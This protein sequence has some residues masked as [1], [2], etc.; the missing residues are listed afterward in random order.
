MV[1][2]NTQERTRMRNEMTGSR[3]ER[4]E[5]YLE[6]G[7]FIA[8]LQADHTAHPPQDVTPTQA[9]IYWIAILFHSISP[10][11][12]EQQPAFVAAFFF[13]IQ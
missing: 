13:E 9:R 4:F 1:P 7:T 3:Q 2:L 6:P 11:A 8:A 5:D 10:Q 12:C